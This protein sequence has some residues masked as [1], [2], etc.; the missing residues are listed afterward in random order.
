MA[1]LRTLQSN[2]NSGE[3]SPLLRG[4]MDVARYQS[5][6]ERCR[7]MLPL[8]GG[9][10]K[11]RAG[12]RWV[13]HA[14]S[15]LDVLLFPLTMTLNGV[16]TGYVLEFSANKIRF[17]TNGAQIESAGSPVEVAT[18]YSADDLAS[19]HYDQL[20]GVL[21]LFH[22][23][24]APRTLTRTSDT[25][26]TLAALA[27]THYP[28]FRPAGTEGVNIIPSGVSG[29]IFLN[30]SAPLFVA[31]HVGVQFQINGGIVEIT[32]VNTA[33]NATATVK[34][35][36]ETGGLRTRANI[37]TVTISPADPSAFTWPHVVTVTTTANYPEQT[38][39]T[40]YTGNSGS[41]VTVSVASSESS[42]TGTEADFDWKESSWSAVRGY[43]FAGVFYEQRLVMT[44]TTSQPTTV[45]GSKIGDLL[46]FTA[47]TL[48][49]DGFSFT[50]AQASTPVVQLVG[51]DQLLALTFNRE[52]TLRGG[53]ETPLSSTNVKVKAPTAH[54]C[55]A[56][57]RPLNLGGVLYFSSPGERNLRAF[58]YRLDLDGYSAP[59]LALLAEHLLEE[60]VGI[61]DMVYARRPYS[62]VFAVTRGG[63]L[64]SLTLDPD[65]EV[66]AW[67]RHDSGSIKSVTVIPDA[68]GNDQVWLAVYRGGGL[69]KIE[70]LDPA[71][72]TDSAATGTDAFGKTT[73]T[74]LS[75]LEGKTVDIVADGYVMPRQV[76]T[77]G[78]VVLDFAA[79]SVQVGLP[80]TSTLKDLPP[81]VEG[82]AGAAASCNAVRVLLHQ[83]Q[84]CSINGEQIPFRHFDLETF[85][86]P[87]APFTGWKEINIASGW[88]PDGD[89]MQVEIV[90]ELPLPLTVLAIAKEV[91][92]NA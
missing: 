6:L 14:A 40:S 58:R 43:P 60:G 24:H 10:V 63:T 80:F 46:N 7:N 82:A 27:I 5:G 42:L 2:L 89:S 29:S 73:W 44:N 17:Y 87:I 33:T 41:E 54:G 35:A 25:A 28:M 61:V 11:R 86:A 65:Q 64:L 71:L 84:G 12:T 9:G 22:P 76:V 13:A 62:A 90:Q 52:L 31:G 67:A 55:S 78:Q 91:S 74:G 69:S 51:G 68:A 32:A 48:D 20:D 18:P 23:N 4:R 19:I 30:S 26:W 3:L 56:T 16:L 53:Q 34:Q 36:I 8:V 81:Y 15:V 21:Y 49:D 66:V 1:K 77:S 37:S 83:A 85:D 57:V 75:H 59:D 47:G 72:T 39:S 92:I 79:K 45:W 70:Y 88:S 50:L 38:I